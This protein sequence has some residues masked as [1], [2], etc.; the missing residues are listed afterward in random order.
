MEVDPITLYLQERDFVLSDLL[1]MANHL[2]VISSEKGEIQYTDIV[3]SVKKV[4]ELDDEE[5]A[6]AYAG[7][8]YEAVTVPKMKRSTPS[9]RLRELNTEETMQQIVGRIRERKYPSN[10]SFELAS[11]Q[12]VQASSSQPRSVSPFGGFEA[13]PTGGPINKS[14]NISRFLSGLRKGGMDLIVP[15]APYDKVRYK[16]I[17][18]HLIF[19]ILFL[20]LFQLLVIIYVALKNLPP[21]AHR[22]LMDMI[23]T[24]KEQKILD[25][26]HLVSKTKVRG[27]FSLLKN[28]NAMEAPNEV[29]E[30]VRLHL[31]KGIT[32]FLE[33]K[34]IHDEYIHRCIL[35]QRLNL[36]PEDRA[37]LL[38]VLD[39]E[40]LAE[41]MKYLAGLAKILEEYFRSLPALSSSVPPL[42]AHMTRSANIPPSSS[43]SSQSLR[44]QLSGYSNPPSSYSGA[45]SLASQPSSYSQLFQAPSHLGSGSAYLSSGSN[46][47]NSSSRID[48]LQHRP[49]QSRFSAPVQSHPH[50]FQS[51]SMPA[52]RFPSDYYGNYDN[53]PSSSSSSSFSSSYQNISSMSTTNLL[54]E[55][56]F[57]ASSQPANTSNSNFD[58][59]WNSLAG[60]LSDIGQSS[61]KNQDEQRYFFPSNS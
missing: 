26:L 52:Q 3:D 29:G 43:S 30:G 10:S 18:P 56:Q 46:S 22:E 21:M 25:E 17:F 50:Q 42:P 28:A 23:L 49:P 48:Y 16:Y 59:P 35:Q 61:L 40:K 13:E 37:E 38:W 54:P 44:P 57:S 36:S 51:N 45:S 31:G 4:K 11:S 24:V 55:P 47:I 14:E 19:I 53:R 2:R 32:S 1:E 12:F 9:L 60:S 6:Q 41:R 20:F 33:F 15:Q 34:A 7:I 39:Q 8:L 58:D 27:I 5:D